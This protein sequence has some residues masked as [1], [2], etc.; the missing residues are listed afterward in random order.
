MY[1]PSI[2]QLHKITKENCHHLR[3]KV[4]MFRTNLPKTRVEQGLQGTFS[5]NYIL[6]LKKCTNQ[7][8]HKYKD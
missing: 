8:K 3:Q 2:Y 1:T 7:Q 4:H 5:I 6:K